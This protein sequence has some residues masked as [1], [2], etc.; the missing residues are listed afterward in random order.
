MF[1]CFL[2]LNPDTLVGLLSVS[3]YGN[4][5]VCSAAGAEG[6]KIKIEVVWVVPTVFLHHFPF[7]KAFYVFTVYIWLNCDL[8]HKPY[9]Q[10]DGILLSFMLS[11]T[12]LFLPTL[13]SNSF[14]FTSRTP[15]GI[16]LG[17]VRFVWMYLSS[18]VLWS[19][20]PLLVLLPP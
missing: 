1:V 10:W 11:D 19:C 9:L 12:D 20:S 6:E 14:H 4:N 3:C 2:M 15:S 5:S 7:I 8:F 17:G 18:T 13:F 16:E